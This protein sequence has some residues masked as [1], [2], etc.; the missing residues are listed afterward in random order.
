M[1]NNKWGAIAL[2]NG[3]DIHDVNYSVYP[4]KKQQKTTPVQLYF[5]QRFLWLPTKGGTNE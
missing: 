3:T 4:L 1:I 5:T 2:T